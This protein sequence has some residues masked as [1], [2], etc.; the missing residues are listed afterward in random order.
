MGLLWSLA[1]HPRVPGHPDDLDGAVGDGRLHPLTSG[2]FRSQA[3][4]DSLAQFAPGRAQGPDDAIL[5]ILP[6]LKAGDSLH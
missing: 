2:V 5:D 4:F 1:D 6:R 3:F